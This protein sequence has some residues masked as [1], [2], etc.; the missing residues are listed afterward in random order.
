M[1]LR[2]PFERVDWVN[3]SFLIGTTIVTLTA[4]PIYLWN[5]GLNLFQAG[6]FLFFAF[7]TG[8]SIT[9]G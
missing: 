6:M 9:L 7:A 2:I 4:V 5:Y 3:S 8:L 1:K